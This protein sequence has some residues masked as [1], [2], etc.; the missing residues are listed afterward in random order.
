MNSSSSSLLILVGECPVSNVYNL[1]NNN[2]VD[3][4]ETNNGLIASSIGS[5]FFGMDSEVTV[6][7]REEFTQSANL[8]NASNFDKIRCLSDGK[9]SES[10][11]RCKS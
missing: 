4:N 2:F 7:C 5:G 10:L 3:L 9:W 8:L 1:I 11:L 6:S